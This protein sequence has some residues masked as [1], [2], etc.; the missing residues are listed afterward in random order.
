MHVNALSLGNACRHRLD[1]AAA[2]GVRRSATEAGGDEV[3]PLIDA[4]PRPEAAVKGAAIHERLVRE[5]GFT[6][7]YQRVKLRPQEARFRIAENRVSLPVNRLTCTHRSEVVP[8]ARTQEA[9][10]KRCGSWCADADVR[11]TTTGRGTGTRTERRQ[12]ARGPAHRPRPG[13][14]Q[15]RRSESSAR[16]RSPG[17]AAPSPPPP[18]RASERCGTAVRRRATACGKME[19]PALPA[20]PATAGDR[21]GLLRSRARASAVGLPVLV[22]DRFDRS[23]AAVCSPLPKDLTTRPQTAAPP[24]G[25]TGHAPERVPDETPHPA[26]PVRRAGLLASHPTRG[27]G[28]T[29]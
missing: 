17:S 6:G 23:A 3:A 11:R 12:P 5:H 22:A 8:G 9:L 21:A 20:V 15:A 2:V 27:P 10:S 18:R 13:S 7:N 26:F 14:R 1:G 16:D 29:G 24:L 4:V 19:D 25:Q 28:R